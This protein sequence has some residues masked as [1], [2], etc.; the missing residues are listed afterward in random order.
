MRDM[1]NLLFGLLFLAIVGFQVLKQFL[2][3]RAEQKK[4]RR[5]ALAQRDTLAHREPLATGAPAPVPPAKLPVQLPV[6]LSETDWGRAPEPA[7]EP[8]ASRSQP[9]PAAAPNTVPNTVPNTA[10]PL[11]VTMALKSLARS[12]AATERAPAAPVAG[13][14]PH[15]SAR[16][17]YFRS[18]RDM[19]A[20]I[21]HMT[22]LGPCR[23]LDPYDKESS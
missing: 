5:Q 16:R 19:R 2:A 20:A 1:E 7:A 3:A 12:R 11:E 8:V 21:V 9:R 10:V 15:G 13:V 23:A 22:V 14:R 4:R 6:E 17:R 18:R